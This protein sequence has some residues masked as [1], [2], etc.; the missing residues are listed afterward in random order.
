MNRIASAIILATVIYAGSNIGCFASKPSQ[1][2]KDDSRLEMI[3]QDNQASN[4]EGMFPAAP[5]PGS[6]GSVLYCKDLDK[7]ESCLKVVLYD[8]GKPEKR[9]PIKAVV[10]HKGKALGEYIFPWGSDL[11]FQSK[12]IDNDGKPE[13]IFGH[14]KDYAAFKQAKGGFKAMPYKK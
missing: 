13:V 6:F 5:E 14:G 4:E 8:Q 12:D 11:Q 7:L 3:A 1:K 9:G 10:S 2:P